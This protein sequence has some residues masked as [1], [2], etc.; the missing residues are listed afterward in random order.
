MINYREKLIDDISHLSD[1]QAKK[2][3]TFF[4]ILKKEFVS[5]PNSNDD[6]KNDFKKITVWTDDNFDE[7][8]KGFNHWP[9]DEF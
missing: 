2:F 1:D 4:Q 9:I 5:K 8:R 7:I 3:Y 6:W